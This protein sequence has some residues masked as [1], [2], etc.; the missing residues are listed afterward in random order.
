[1][2]AL[3]CGVLWRVKSPRQSSD[4]AKQHSTQNETVLERETSTISFYR[5]RKQYLDE[6]FL[7]HFVYIYIYLR[8]ISEAVEAFCGRC[9]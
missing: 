2:D 3:L 4:A 1:M 6:V 5:I 7:P 8:S 9:L